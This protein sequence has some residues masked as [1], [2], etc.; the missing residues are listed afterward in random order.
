MQAG[1]PLRAALTYRRRRTELRSTPTGG[2]I[3]KWKR[4]WDERLDAW[5]RPPQLGFGDPRLDGSTSATGAGVGHLLSALALLLLTVFAVREARWVNVAR[6]GVSPEWMVLIGLPLAWFLVH[7]SQRR[8]GVAGRVVNALLFVLW[9]GIG[10]AV[11][12]Q[13][14]LG[15]MPSPVRL[16]RVAAT[17]DWPGLLNEI[18]AQWTSWGWRLQQWWLGVQTGG[19]AR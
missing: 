4:R 17:A 16:Q 9:L 8:T 12:S 14:I 5:R 2:V 19:A 13:V 15:W 11:T 18:L 3:A 10:G 7:R 1:A 6:Y